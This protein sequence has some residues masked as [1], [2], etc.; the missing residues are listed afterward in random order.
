MFI[1]PA[2]P[3]DIPTLS[4][5][6]RAA[7]ADV[8]ERFGLTPENCP[9][10]PSN[11][12]PEWISDALAKGTCYFVL[13]HE[14]RIIGCV[15]LEQAQTAVCYLERLA[16]LPEYRKQGAGKTLVEQ[17]L[18]EARRRGA[19]RVEIGIIAAHESLRAWYASFGFEEIRRASFPHLPFE[20]LFMRRNL[21][22]T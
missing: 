13:E 3:N 21:P 19:Q 5:V 4:S 8:A 18:M 20:V 1:R 14:G 11:C 17:A 9:R 22:A 2:T 7:F 15:A 16:V 10:H 12:Q 6:I